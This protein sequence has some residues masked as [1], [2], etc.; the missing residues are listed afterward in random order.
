MLPKKRRLKTNSL[1]LLIQKGKRFDFDCFYIKYLK[2]NGPPQFS[3][4]VSKKIST[5]A[6][7]RNFLRRKGYQALGDSLSHFPDGYSFAFFLKR[8]PELQKW[9]S[10][11]E[12]IFPFLEKL[13][14]S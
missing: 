6:T 10:V 5:K 14:R 9:P 3:F 1:N 12:P 11:M 4:V 8:K 13:K 2:I 7:S